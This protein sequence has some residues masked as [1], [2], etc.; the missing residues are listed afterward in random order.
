MNLSALQF[1]GKL[2]WLDGHPLL[3]V[4]EPYRRTIFASALDARDAAGHLRYNLIL[5][6]RGKKNFKSCDLVLASLY[7]LVTDSPGGNQCYLFA[8]DEGQAADDLM[9][10][11]ALIAANPWLSKH[12]AVKQ[13]VA[14]RRD[15]RGFLEILPA[16]D[17]AGS[18]GK[19]YR[20]AAFDEI[21][22]QRTWDLLEAMQLDPTRPD[23]QMWI[24]SYASLYHKPG[25]PLHDLF[26]QGKSGADPRMYFSW[27]SG[28]YTTDDDLDLG[29]TAEEKANPSRG[30]FAPDYLEQQRRRLPSWAFRRL[31]LNEP[32]LPA[33]SAFNIE[34]VADAIAR[35]TRLRPPVPGL[36]YFGFADPSGGSND[37]FTF[38]VAHL[39]AEGRAILDVV[40]N[41]GP[42]P[43]FDPRQAVARFADLAKRYGLSRIYG[44]RFAGHTFI[45]D[46]AT[47]GLAY[48]VSLSSASEMY[49]A[50]E[51]VLNSHRAVLLDQPLL[52]S[53]LLGLC[54][55]GNKIDHPGN[56]H[57]DWCNAA[58]GA[59]LVALDQPSGAAHS[60]DLED[61]LDDDI[62]A[63]EMGG[64][65]F[66]QGW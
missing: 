23:A 34:P 8:S 31:H 65:N 54:W 11:K 17:V 62:V 2:R 12:L 40:T 20:L 26:Q 60:G 57:D 5:C 43:P 30:M 58:V 46:F 59:L 44:D 45:A 63:S 25:V 13:K 6:G 66:L 61:D 53:Q 39:D 4:I 22:T 15:G 37:D 35:G 55:R 16:Q 18:H 52:E 24:T 42:R 48:E 36:Q 38:A 56:E 41:Q 47:H 27:Y 51:P 19:T 29:G 9:L 64:G 33:G 49:S 1:F 14:E 10:A 21:H 7:A 32:G 28:S 50:F 3:S